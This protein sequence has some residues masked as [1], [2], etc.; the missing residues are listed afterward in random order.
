[1]EILTS[2]LIS[3]IFLTTFLVSLP[4]TSSDY[5]PLEGWG[6]RYKDW[7]ASNTIYLN[8]TVS[9]SI[10]PEIVVIEIALSLER[11]HHTF[12]LCRNGRS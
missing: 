9:Y 2:Q 10:T 7:Q 3:W 6:C 5:L 4:T 11:K 12:K 1:M 8:M